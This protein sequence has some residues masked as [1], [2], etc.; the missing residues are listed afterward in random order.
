[1]TK[2]SQRCPSLL[3]VYPKEY[4]ERQCRRLLTDRGEREKHI[5]HHQW[6]PRYRSA[7]AQLPSPLSVPHDMLIERAH[8]DSHWFYES[9][10]AWLPPFL[11]FLR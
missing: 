4:H 2:Q 7:L 5:F 6:L 11:E 1:M 3:K 10:G 9:G 8:T